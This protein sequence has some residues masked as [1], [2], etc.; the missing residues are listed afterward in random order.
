MSGVSFITDGTSEV[1]SGEVA[2]GGGGD[3]SRSRDVG[4]G[5]GDAKAG[6]GEEY[7]EGADL[8]NICCGDA[9]LGGGIIK[10]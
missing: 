5:G 10:R 8:G 3:T 1:E 6:F 2:G 9:G 7:L 4:D